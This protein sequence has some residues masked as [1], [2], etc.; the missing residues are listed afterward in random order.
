MKNCWGKIVSF[1]LL[2]QVYLLKVWPVRILSTFDT[3]FDTISGT[4]DISSQSVKLMKCLSLRMSFM[5]VPCQILTNEAWVGE[6]TISV[7]FFQTARKRSRLRL[8]VG[9]EIRKAWPETQ[10]NAW[11]TCCHTCVF[12]FFLMDIYTDV[13]IFASKHAQKRWQVMKPHEVG[14]HSSFRSNNLEICLKKI[15]AVLFLLFLRI[16]WS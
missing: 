7:V 4:L 1:Q 11:E 16:C 6:E 12:F 10:T 14:S 15:S 9:K 8:T 5:T 13:L 3:L 2:R